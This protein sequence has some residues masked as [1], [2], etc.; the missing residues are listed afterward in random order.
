MLRSIQEQQA[1]RKYVDHFVSASGITDTTPQSFNNKS[2]GEVSIYSFWIT[3]KLNSGT[4]PDNIFVDFTK[5]LSNP[6][7]GESPIEMNGTVFRKTIPSSDI[8]SSP[9]GIIVNV[10]DITPEGGFNLLD[11]DITADSGGSGYNIDVNMYLI[12]R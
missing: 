9:K 7:A 1:G 2:M 3:C 12:G 8:V 10:A 4:A 5:K 11:I 6:A